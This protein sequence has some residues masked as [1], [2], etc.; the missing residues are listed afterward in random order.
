MVKVQLYKIT[1][2]ITFDDHSIFLVKVI[3]H[4]STRDPE[5]CFTQN[6]DEAQVLMEKLANHLVKE[7]S[8]DS[9]VANGKV[10][11]SLEK[12]D[13][14]LV[15]R[16]QTLGRLYNGTSTPVYTLNYCEVSH[17]FLNQESSQTSPSSEPQPSSSKAEDPL[18][19]L[20]AELKVI[21]DKVGPVDTDEN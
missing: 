4:D 11:I 8:E 19:K 18:D 7:L 1:D 14:S 2:T 15:I 17:G 20:I 10:R 12:A 6:R 5:F 9:A 16:K 13:R 21:L 3:E